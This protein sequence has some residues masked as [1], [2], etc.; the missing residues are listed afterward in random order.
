M[1]D[2]TATLTSKTE[3]AGVMYS[4]MVSRASGAG[5]GAFWT[6][7]IKDKLNQKCIGKHCFDK[8]AAI[9][10]YGKSEKDPLITDPANHKFVY[11]GGG[12]G[13]LVYGIETI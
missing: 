4:V 8:D 1:D 11:G 5:F 3:G 12:G 9:A 13:V 6:D 7:E 10:V 2:G